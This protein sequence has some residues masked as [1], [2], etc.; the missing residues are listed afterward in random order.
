MERSVFW[1]NAV[2]PATHD[3][4]RHVRTKRLFSP[5]AARA[6]HVQ[7]DSCNDAGQPSVEVLDAGGVGAAEAKPG[8]LHSVVRFTQ[9]PSNR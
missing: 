7:T 4:V 6:E 3:G 2:V 1:V 8:L 9:E 5:G